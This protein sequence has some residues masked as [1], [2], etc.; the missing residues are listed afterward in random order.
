MV[1]TGLRLDESGGIG[2][3]DIKI[4]DDRDGGK[5]VIDDRGVLRLPHREHGRRLS[6]QCLAMQAAEGANALV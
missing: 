2:F 4:V 5:T 3:R 1:N 6:R